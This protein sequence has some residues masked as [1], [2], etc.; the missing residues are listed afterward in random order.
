MAMNLA[1]KFSK[2]IDERFKLKSV[3]QVGVNEDYEWTGVATVSVYG[4]DTVAMGDYTRSG[5]N[6]YGNVVELGNTQ[7][8]LTLTRDRAFTFTIDKGNFTESMMVMRSGEALSREI[9]EVVVPEIDIYRLAAWHTAAVANSKDLLD[10]TTDADDAYSNFLGLQESLSDDLVP[11]TGRI[12]FMTAAYYSFLKQSNFVLASEKEAGGRHSGELGT[13]DGAKVVVV[14][15][16]YFVS[17]CDLILVH[18]TA[19]VSPRKLEEYKTHENPP[20]ISGWLVEGRNIYDAFILN[21]KVDG[22][23]IHQAA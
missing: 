6:R 8:D 20:G 19:M 21:N 13:V 4:I 7:Q 11:M 2:K 5:T 14:P 10:S 9:D 12:A 18:P 16:S 17:G 1:S 23:A 22:I 3:T 15:S